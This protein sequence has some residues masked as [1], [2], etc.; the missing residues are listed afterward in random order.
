LSLIALHSNGPRPI[1]A[2]EPHTND[3][4]RIFPHV[5]IKEPDAPLVHAKGLQAGA[6][7][8]VGNIVTPKDG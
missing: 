1:P 2:L 5:A 6:I 3:V 8:L 7:G 4:N